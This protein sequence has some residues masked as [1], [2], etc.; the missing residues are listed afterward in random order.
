MKSGLGDARRRLVGFCPQFDALV[1]QMTVRETLWMYARLRGIHAGDIGRLV[2]KLI[3]QL[4]L[5]EY[6]NRQA[7]KLRYRPKR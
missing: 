5:N 4:T 3:Q 2:D 6:A 7:G 1:D